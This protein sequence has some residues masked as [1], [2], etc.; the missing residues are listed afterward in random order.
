MK[1]SKILQ[2]YKGFKYHWQYY[3]MCCLENCD[4]MTSLQLHPE[5]FFKNI[6]QQLCQSQ[7]VLKER[8]SH[9][10]WYVMAPSGWRGGRNLPLQPLRSIMCCSKW[11]FFLLKKPF[12]LSK[13]NKKEKVEG[14]TSDQHGSGPQQS[15]GRP[16]CPLIGAV[17]NCTDIIGMILI[18]GPPSALLFLKRGRRGRA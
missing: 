4:T 15:E 9:L 12:F 5:C 3:R 2:F 13:R 18:W 8:G 11:P 10:E 7:S 14:W 6:S 1:S 16:L 17:W